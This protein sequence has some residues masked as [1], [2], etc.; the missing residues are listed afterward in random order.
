MRWFVLLCQAM[1][2]SVLTL[3]SAAG[4]VVLPLPLPGFDVTFGDYVDLAAACVKV[5]PAGDRDCSRELLL[6]N[7]ALDSTAK[8]TV[9]AQASADTGASYGS[10]IASATQDIHY[11]LP[12]TASRTI[13]VVRVGDQYIAVAPT[14]SLTFTY[15]YG[16]VAA[17]RDEAGTGQERADVGALT[18]TLT[19]A[20]PWTVGARGQSG[21]TGAPS[22]NV[23][24]GGASRSFTV[25]TGPSVGEVGTIVEIPLSMN[26]WR[27]E[28]SPFV[29]YAAHESFVQIYT[30]TVEVQLSLIARSQAT[31][32][33]NWLGICTEGNG[34]EALACLGKGSG[35][36][37][38]ELDDV[39][40][41]V[42]LDVNLGFDVIDVEQ[43]GLVVSAAL[44]QT[45]IEIEHIGPVPEPASALLM[46]AGI[47]G[48]LAWRR[49]RTAAR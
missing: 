18:V 13:N 7:G 1:L 33:C 17:T 46:L 29:D 38:F 30:G 3:P 41:P 2:W 22:F 25:E 49:H 9:N 28:V 27:D 8:F 23:A 37:G 48:L 26:L 16:A 40:C 5:G 20:L 21:E 45:G 15:E 4:A 24:S 39:G 11:Q 42:D 47:G 31:Q 44:S 43:G 32:N 35:L 34:G 14:L 10:L 6:A 36:S 12:F 19:D